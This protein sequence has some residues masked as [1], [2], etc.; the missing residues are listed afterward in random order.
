MLKGVSLLPALDRL[1]CVNTEGIESKFRLK[2]TRL[3]SD[4]DFEESPVPV[5]PSPSAITAAKE[6]NNAGKLGHLAPCQCCAFY[7]NRNVLDHCA[8]AHINLTQWHYWYEWG[9]SLDSHNV[10]FLMIPTY[11]NVSVCSIV[12]CG[13]S[14]ANGMLF[15]SSSK[16]LSVGEFILT[17]PSFLARLSVENTYIQFNGYWMQAGLT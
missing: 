14:S 17:S 6:N 4:D 16:L 10:S 12:P 13:S 7:I 5:P 2:P 8:N 3:R 1:S 11:I 9:L 15:K